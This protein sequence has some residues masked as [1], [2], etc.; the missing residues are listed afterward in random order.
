MTNAE[1][2]DLRGEIFG[3]KVLLFN[4]L[5]AITANSLDPV[6]TIEAIKTQSLVGILDARPS[7]IRPQHLEVFQ[8]AAAGIVAQAVEALAATYSRSQPPARPQ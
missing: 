1:L 2:A 5:S 6:A 3:L 8:N 4:V 7:S